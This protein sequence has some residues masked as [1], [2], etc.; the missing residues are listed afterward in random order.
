MY[1]Y[2][3][4]DGHIISKKGK[5]FSETFEHL[6]NEMSVEGWEFYSQSDIT[7]YIPGGCLFGSPEIKV[8]QTFI[9]RRQ[10]VDTD[11]FIEEVNLNKKKWHVVPEGYIGYS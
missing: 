8:R 4:I 11:K 5:Q 2:K 3:V 6:L 1:E 10:V 9:F 7:Q